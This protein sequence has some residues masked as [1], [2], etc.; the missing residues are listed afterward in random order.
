MM[1]LL[2]LWIIQSNNFV[3][4]GCDLLTPYFAQA[5]FRWSSLPWMG[6][7]LLTDLRRNHRCMHRLRRRRG[8]QLQRICLQTSSK[9]AQS[10]ICLK[11]A[12][13]RNELLDTHPGSSAELSGESQTTET[14][15]YSTISPPY[16]I[17][18][19]DIFQVWTLH[20]FRNL[21]GRISSFLLSGFWVWFY[22]RFPN[23]LNFFVCVI[24]C[25]QSSMKCW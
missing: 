15:I 5:N 24:K 12:H 1:T 7:W 17:W 2:V 21:S 10:R 3:L 23:Q 6:R 22:F 25:W 19:M 20:H 14:W 16:F 13:G 11:H 9:Q 4:N 18:I 8:R